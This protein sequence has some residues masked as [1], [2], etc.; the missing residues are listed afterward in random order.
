M[1]QEREAKERAEAAVRVRD[2]TLGIV[3]HD[4][5]NPLTTIALSADLLSS[6]PAEQQQELAD[7][8]RL[9]ARQM[10]RLIQDLLD[11]ARVEAG[12]LAIAP[13]EIEVEPLVRE[14]CAANEPI[15]ELK[16]QRLTCDV[17]GPLPT[18]CA[19]RD[20]IVQVLG[21]LIGNALKFTPERGMVVVEVEHRG[22][23]VNFMVR[24]SGPGIPSADLKNVFTPYWQAKK[25]AHMGAGLGL[26]IVRG[27]VEA[28]GGQVWAENVA[29]GGAM[30]T[31]TI[32]TA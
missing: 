3:S 21:N 24:D 7:T 19:D 1:E 25:T 2:E 10:Q 27:I 32:P 12:G 29:A 16:K 11:V 28:H 15:A 13:V 18:I 9:S 5:R 22:K 30:F 23:C 31:F 14:V 6:A 17:R 4:L 8:I 20:R 26:A